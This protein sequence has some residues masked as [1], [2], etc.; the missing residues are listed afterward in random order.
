M[1]ENEALMIH[2][3]K[4]CFLETISLKL[5]VNENCLSGMNGINLTETKSTL[6]CFYSEVENT[7]H[8]K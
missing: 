4:V 2:E 7:I 1:K 8:I 6:I 3:V 5:N